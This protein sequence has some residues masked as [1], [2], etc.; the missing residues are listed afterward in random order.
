MARWRWRP[1][2]DSDEAPAVAGD[3]RLRWAAR[4]RAAGFGSCA[5]GLLLTMLVGERLDLLTWFGGGAFLFAV[6]PLVIMQVHLS[7][8]SDLST[9]QKDEWSGISTSEAAIIAAFFYLVRGA[10]RS[11]RAPRNPGVEAPTVAEEIRIVG[12]EPTRARSSHRQRGDETS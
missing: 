1:L 5:L 3:R 10:P 8:A 9:A 11:R 2:R 12:V 4:F 7:V 6:L